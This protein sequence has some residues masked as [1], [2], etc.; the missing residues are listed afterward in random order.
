MA[1]FIEQRSKEPL[2]QGRPIITGFSQGGML[3]F[4][5]AALYPERIRAS[6]PIAG[7]LPDRLWESFAIGPQGPPIF[8]LHGEQDQVIP[9]GPTEQNVQRLAAAGYPASILRFPGVAHRVPRPVQTAWEE[10]LQRLLDD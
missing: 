5:M 3:S 8:A 4:A 7:M 6:V 2:N 9:L 1:S 10:Q